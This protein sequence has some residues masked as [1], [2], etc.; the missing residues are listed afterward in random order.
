VA[1][2]GVIGLFALMGLGGVP[3][4]EEEQGPAEETGGRIA[5]AAEEAK[6]KAE[7]A[8]EEAGKKAEEAGEKVREQTEN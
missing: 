7:E 6:R 4:C 2:W 5:E 8:T 1:R 3:G